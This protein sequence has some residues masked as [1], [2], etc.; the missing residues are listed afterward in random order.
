MQALANLRRASNVKTYLVSN[1][2]GRVA[3][4]RV[5][6]QWLVVTQYDAAHHFHQWRTKQGT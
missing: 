4:E 2:H 6:D 3:H 1:E 5:S